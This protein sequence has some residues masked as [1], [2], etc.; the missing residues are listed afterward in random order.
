M[1]FRVYC[2]SVAL[3]SAATGNPLAS[4]QPEDNPG[5]L[6]LW[7]SDGDSL[8]EA[9]LNDDS[10]T[11]PSLNSIFSDAPSDY[12][13]FS[14]GDAISAAFQTG[15]DGEATDSLVAS[16]L[17]VSNVDSSSDLDILISRDSL[18]DTWTSL[19]PAT[20]ENQ[21]IDPLN[22]NRQPSPQPELRIPSLEDDF[23]SVEC[24]PLPDGRKRQPLCCYKEDIE[25]SPGVHV[26]QGCWNCEYFR[27]FLH[28]SCH[29][30]YT[31]D[32][33]SGN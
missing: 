2:I 19:R 17:G 20:E 4:P 13:L 23:D 6:D 27:R 5:S 18:T 33:L 28:K 24:P 26:A 15:S 12:S 10:L 30:K 29:G 11:L 31:N 14:D 21:C 9:P 8:T 7:Q 3:L 16:C 32:Y 22:R 25:V 1:H